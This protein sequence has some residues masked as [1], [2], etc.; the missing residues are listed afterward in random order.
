M[1]E[2]I[3]AFFILSGVCAWG[4]IAYIFIN[5]FWGEK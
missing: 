2:I 5:L 4:F 3:F 1:I